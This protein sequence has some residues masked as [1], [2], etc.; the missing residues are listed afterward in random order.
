MPRSFSN[1]ISYVNN[2]DLTLLPFTSR[3]GVR[4]RIEINGASAV[5]NRMQRSSGLPGSPTG[6]G[7]RP[8]GAAFTLV[9][10]LVV[11]AIIALLASML[12]PALSRA[13]GKGQQIYCLNNHKQLT[14]AAQLYADDY[15]Q[16]LPPIQERLSGNVETSWRPYLFKYLGRSAKTFDC[17]VEKVE[18]YASGKPSNSKTPSPVGHRS[19]GG[20]RDRNPER[21]RCGERPLVGRGRAAAVRPA[22]RLREQPLPHRRHRVAFALDLLR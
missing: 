11:I 10:L 13:K 20:R 1:W 22:R 21:Y 12:L 17:P 18:V 3:S 9:E 4:K 2:T 14:L 19:A 8:A 6:G 15:Q 16:W 5:Q 7:G